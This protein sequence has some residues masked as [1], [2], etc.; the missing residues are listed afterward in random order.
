M[1]VYMSSVIK[2]PINVATAMTTIIKICIFIKDFILPRK[3]YY[4]Y[5]ESL[6]NNLM[7]FVISLILKYLKRIKLTLVF[8]RSLTNTS[9][10]KNWILRCF[11]TRLRNCL[12]VLKIV[13]F[14]M[15]SAYLIFRMMDSYSWTNS[16]TSSTWSTAD[17]TQ[18]IVKYISIF[19]IWMPMELLRRLRCYESCRISVII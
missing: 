18:I 8:L 19:Q 6:N 14:N 17:P 4:K 11:V 5:A 15:F 9:L 13:I 16:T 3:L 10:I 1:E 7:N 12:H 2:Q